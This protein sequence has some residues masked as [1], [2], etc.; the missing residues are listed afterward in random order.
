MFPRAGGHVRQP[1]SVPA[2]G[3][4]S[5][6]RS[7][8]VHHAEGAQPRAVRAQVPRIARLAI[9]A[10]RRQNNP[11]RRDG[12]VAEGAR[13]ESVYTGNRIVGS[14]PTLSANTNLGSF[15]CFNAGRCI[16]VKLAYFERDLSTA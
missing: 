16:A 3:V 8:L 5:R 13:L 7:R 11:R 1:L 10:G 12:R 15:L 6:G 4:Q 9:D 14:N 2:R